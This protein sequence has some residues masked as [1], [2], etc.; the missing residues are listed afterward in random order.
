MESDRVRGPSM[1]QAVKWYEGL[2]DRQKGELNGLA[3]R[4]IIRGHAMRGEPSWLKP[5]ARM[6]LIP[7]LKE[8]AK[9]FPEY[10]SDMI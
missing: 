5:E 10:E 2:D 1:F 8:L 6:F 4:F 9:E 3:Y 7:V